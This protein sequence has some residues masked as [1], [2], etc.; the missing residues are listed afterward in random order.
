M[1]ELDRT[2]LTRSRVILVEGITNPSKIAYILKD[3]GF[4][5]VDSCQFIESYPTQIRQTGQLLNIIPT[6]GPAIF[7]QFIDILKVEYPNLAVIL[8]ERKR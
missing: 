6:R 1:D 7:A 5:T 3:K 4:L 8:Q 2:I